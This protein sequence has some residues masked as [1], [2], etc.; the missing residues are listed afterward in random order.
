MYMLLN[1]EDKRW[2]KTKGK[3][4]SS[5]KELF[6]LHWEKKFDFL[7]YPKSGTT[8]LFCY[9]AGNYKLFLKIF[10]STNIAVQIVIPSPTRI[11]TA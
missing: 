6:T 11:Q 1:M 8:Y 7:I 9:I 10:C 5:K 2:E 4:G 3:K